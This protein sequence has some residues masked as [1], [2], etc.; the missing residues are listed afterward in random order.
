MP[1]STKRCTTRS[2]SPTLA[3]RCG[4]SAMASIVARL[5]NGRYVRL[6]PVGLLPP[7]LHRGAGRVDVGVVDLDDAEGVRA[8]A[9]A[10]QHV[11]AGELADLRQRDRLVA[12]PGGD[13]RRGRRLGGGGRRRGRGRLRGRRR[14]L[15]GRRLVG[16]APARPGAVGVAPTLSMWSSTSSRVMRPPGPLPL[17]AAGSSP[18]S[19]TRR[20]TT[21]DSSTPLAL[22]A[23]GAA[24]GSG[25]AAGS[26]SGAGSS[27]VA[28]A[29]SGSSAGVSVAGA[30]VAPPCSGSGASSAAAPPPPAPPRREPPRPPVPARSAAHRRRRRRRR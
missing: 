6:K 7:V 4:K 26:G 1:R 12:L 11:G 20:R 10:H 16:A 27:A 2:F 23:A 22:D 15:G 30:S 9:L 13:R 8:D 24:S 19:L 25:S 21:G 14:R 28:S 29:G 3:F 18:C 17:I 5:M